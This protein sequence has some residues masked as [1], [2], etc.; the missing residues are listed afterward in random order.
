MNFP[1][2]KAL[3]AAILLAFSHSVLAADTE[4][5]LD[6]VVV[7]ANRVARTAEDTLTSVSVIT[8]KDIEQKQAA[9]V[10]ELLSGLPGVQ[11]TNNGGIGKNTSLFL[12]G[13]ND[14]HTLVL[15]DG[16]RVGSATLG[17]AGLQDLPVEQ[18]ERIELVRGPRASLYGSEA[19]GGVIQ[20]F[21]RK[22]P[23]P[24]AFS[25]GGGSRQTYQGSATGGF[26]S[27]DLWLNVGASGFA[28]HGINV[29]E[30]A[31]E[32]DKDGY[33][34]SSMN[35]RGGGRIGQSLNWD[36]QTL[37]TEARNK[38]D[39]N[40]N[41]TDVKQ[42]LYTGN[43]QY[44]ANA[45]YNTSLR[46]AQ[47][48]DASTNL[49]E[50]NF[51]SRIDTRRSQ[52]SWQNDF[53]LAEG[54]QLVGGL[55]Y[56]YDEV[57]SNS[58]FSRTKRSNRA[59][60]AEYLGE[61][62]QADLQLSARHDSN[63][64]YGHHNTGSIAA[65]YS[66]SQAL[67][68]RSSYGT[69]FKAPSFNDLYYP[70]SGNPNLQP[71]TSRTIEAGAGGKLGQFSWDASV[72]KTRINNLIAWAPD[73]SGNY[74]PGNVS[75]AHITGLELSASQKFGNTTVGASATLLNPKDH[76]GG[77]TEGNLLARR[78]RQSGRIDVDQLIGQWSVGAS[79]NGTGK[80]YDAAN[81][82]VKMGGY[83][84][85]DLRV[86]YRFNPEWRIQTRV[87]NVFDKRYQTVSTYN[88]PGVGAFVTLR[89]QPK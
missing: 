67:R 62:G 55:D 68:V 42:D 36:L 20:I 84:T 21:T 80:R 30:T 25:L 85:A 47:N 64:Q 46:L 14:G 41:V 37:H 78:S 89:Y 1:R 17:S 48:L 11:F 71:E 15:I 49:K 74:V 57:L 72:F 50:D 86:E 76:S 52:A 88:Q 51:S 70:S 56:V 35:V 9:T 65:G 27:Q 69:A 40:P 54:Q 63:E 87:E 44:T 73:A 81:N 8:R 66:F 28:T 26:G 31:N 75:R 58:A 19:I 38:Y 43:L 6:D 53:S 2:S 23:Q 3:P 60:F 77:A 13:T 7:T 29:R 59:A 22:G 24:A 34:R 82:T 45:R 79:L 10:P 39:G 32:P 18:I 5:V 12:R 33:T 61:F 4:T 16:V 83:A